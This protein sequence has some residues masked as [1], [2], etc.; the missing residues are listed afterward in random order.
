MN[1]WKNVAAISQNFSPSFLGYIVHFFLLP[2]YFA[3]GTSFSGTIVPKYYS[4][5]F[6]FRDFLEKTAVE[7]SSADIFLYNN[8]ATAGRRGLAV[9]SMS[10]IDGQGHLL[11]SSSI[12][13]YICET[14]LIKLLHISILFFSSDDLDRSLNLEFLQ[15]FVQVEKL[16]SDEE[17][18]KEGIFLQFRLWEQGRIDMEDMVER[19]E[20]IVKHALWEVVT[21]Y[22]LMPN[23]F[24]ASTSSISNSSS[25]MVSTMQFQYLILG[26]TYFFFFFV[27][28]QHLLN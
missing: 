24:M 27:K 19:F 7:V 23:D 25:S 18:E 14:P 16:S 5:R 2:T 21:E 13:K 15:T 8:S 6:I 3:G 20:A 10:I 12:G 26:S 9:F 11:H 17:M 22:Y 4:Q 1:F 28:L